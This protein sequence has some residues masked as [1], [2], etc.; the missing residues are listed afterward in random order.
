MRRTDRDERAPSL[1][2]APT[3]ASLY[4]LAAMVADEASLAGHRD[5]SKAIETAMD[6]FLATLP[7]DQ[8]ANALT[9]SYEIAMNCAG[10]SEEPTKP[11]LR[12][13]YSR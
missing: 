7:P 1:T 2:E 8:Q 4:C 13:V 11:R 10:D 5:F 9:L 6:G 3:A 12:L